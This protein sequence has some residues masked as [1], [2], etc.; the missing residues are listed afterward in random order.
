[1]GRGVAGPAPGILRRRRRDVGQRPHSHRRLC[2]PKPHCGRRTADRCG[3]L[4][5][6]GGLQGA[7]A[8]VGA[9]APTYGAGHPAPQPSRTRPMTTPGSIATQMYLAMR[10]VER[11]LQELASALHLPPYEAPAGKYRD[12]AYADMVRMR[13]LASYLNDA[14]ATLDA[15]GPELAQQVGD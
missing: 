15:L 2:G 8:A 7:A 11:A 12:R 6:A 13:A 14:V 5:R 10:D 9:T 1:A 3:V 4:H